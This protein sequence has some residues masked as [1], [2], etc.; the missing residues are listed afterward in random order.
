LVDN[1]PAFTK[2]VM[3]L[4]GQLI[5]HYDVGFPLGFVDSVDAKGV[6]LYNHLK[7]IIH[8][9]KVK[10][11]VYRIVGFEVEPASIKHAYK[12][13]KDEETKLLTCG[14]SKFNMMLLNADDVKEII[15]TFDV[16][17]VVRIQVFS[18]FDL[19]I[20]SGF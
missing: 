13:W 12:S 4:N 19:T 10:D 20:V 11:A 8:V 15:Y 2:Q 17:W 1:L 6:Y 5:D 16:K 3:D 18:A 9:Y 7:F 14:N